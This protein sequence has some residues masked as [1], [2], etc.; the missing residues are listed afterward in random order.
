MCA[1]GGSAEALTGDGRLIV[2]RMIRGSAA[3]VVRWGL[4]QPLL[5]GSKEDEM[6]P[7]VTEILECRPARLGSGDPPNSVLKTSPS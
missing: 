4:F 1:N 6:R 2:G 7:A 5:W 3:V